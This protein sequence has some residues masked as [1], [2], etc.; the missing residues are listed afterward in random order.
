MVKPSTIN[1]PYGKLRTRRRAK[2]ANDLDRRLRGLDETLPNSM[3][4][5]DTEHD[6]QR[7]YIYEKTSSIQSFQRLRGFPPSAETYPS[8]SGLLTA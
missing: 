6:V 7:I 2:Q 5:G 8:E 3:N 1:P 4:M